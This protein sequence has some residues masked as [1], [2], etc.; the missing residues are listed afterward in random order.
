MRRHTLLT[1]GLVVFLLAALAA[2][3]V[4]VSMPPV[5][6]EPGQFDANRA[7]ARLAFIL[8]D[9]APHPVDSPTNDKVRE[10]LV[11]SL[12]KMGLRPIVRDQTVCNDF[13]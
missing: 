9:Q 2:K 10:R 5:R 12:R 4:L 6:N 7:K 1:L 11:E 13:Q 8:G 3:S